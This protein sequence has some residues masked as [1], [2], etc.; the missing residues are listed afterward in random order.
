MVHIFLRYIEWHYAYRSDYYGYVR[1]NNACK[2]SMKSTKSAAKENVQLGVRIPV[3]KTTPA[4]R[5]YQQM[6]Y[7]KGPTT[8]AM[9]TIGVFK[10]Q[11]ELQQGSVTR[12][13][14]EMLT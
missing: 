6:E 11:E 7:T 14:T 5:L 2:L 9:N 4:D 10:Q 3:R 13:T 8:E 12:F 1:N